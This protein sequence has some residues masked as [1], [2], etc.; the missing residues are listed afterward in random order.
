MARA[1]SGNSPTALDVVTDEVTY[2]AFG[3]TV[4]K[5]GST[6]NPWGYKG[7]MG[8]YTNGGTEDLYVRARHL[9]PRLGRWLSTDPLGSGMNVREIPEVVRNSE[10]IDRI[11]DDVHLYVY[12]ANNPINLI[13]P[14]GLKSWREKDACETWPKLCGTIDKCSLIGKVRRPGYKVTTNGCTIVPDKVPILA[15]NGSFTNACDN[16]DICWQN[17][18]IPLHVCQTRFREDMYRECWLAYTAYSGWNPIGHVGY[19]AC[20]S[21]AQAYYQATTLNVWY[22]RSGQRKACAPVRH[23]CTQK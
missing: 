21:T 22:W 11:G 23:C 20:L 16:H 3:E 2:T 17:C 8:Y 4:S 13:D 10:V 12:V 7:A 9:A 14:T 6:V 5:T 1:L 18:T 15:F 19:A